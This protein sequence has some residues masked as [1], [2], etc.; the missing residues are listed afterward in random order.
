MEIR[1][2]LEE[3]YK[4][5]LSVAEEM[6]YLFRSL[7]Q[8]SLK[9]IVSKIVSANQFLYLDIPATLKPIGLFLIISGILM[10]TLSVYL[11]VKVGQGTPAV[12]DPPKKFVA[13]GP[14]KYVR[15][16]MYISGISILFGFAFWLQS[17]NLLHSTSIFW[18]I[19]H[20]FLVAFEEPQLEKRFG[21]SYVKYKSEVPRWIPKLFRKDKQGQFELIQ[22]SS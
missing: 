15:N 20:V 1:K 17:S 19:L 4:E 16:P 9:F 22:M 2:L 14:Y 5:M 13:I 3:G 6:T 12:Y 10:A 21:K 7:D 8:D 18:L 11:F